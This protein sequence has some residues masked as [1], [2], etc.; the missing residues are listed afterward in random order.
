MQG[1]WGTVSLR[2]PNYKLSLSHVC[3]ARS[4]ARSKNI[5]VA[6]TPGWLRFRRKTKCFFGIQSSFSL[7]PIPKLS[8]AEFSRYQLHAIFSAVEDALKFRGVATLMQCQQLEVSSS[9]YFFKVL[10]SR[11]WVCAIRSQNN[12]RDDCCNSRLYSSLRKPLS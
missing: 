2:Y 6:W 12:M 5:T 7:S 11:Q 1:S 10:C 4:F 9:R 8:P 3:L